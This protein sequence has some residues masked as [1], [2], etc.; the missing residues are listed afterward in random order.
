MKKRIMAVLL[1]IGMLM[2]ACGAPVTEERTQQE[3]G[4]VRDESD[5][6]LLMIYMVGSDLESEAG[7]ASRDIREIVESGFD[8]E[9]LE[10]LICTGGT[11]YWWTEGIS[12]EACGIYEVTDGELKPVYTM[13]NKNM[14]EAGT[15]TEFIDYAYGNYMA[16][17]YSL[18]MW[19]HGGGAVL[20][21]GADENYDYDALSLE[22]MD[23]AFK[24]TMLAAD[25]KKFEWVGFDACLMSMIEVADMLSEYADYMLASEEV[26]AGDGWDY[27][28]LKTISNGKYSEGAA[29]TAEI[30][31]AYSAHYENDYKYTPDYTLA[32]LDLSKTNEVISGLENLVAV[33]GDELRSGGYSKIAK[34]RDQA[35]AFGKVSSAGFYDTVDLYD[36]AGQMMALYP[37]QA[38]A[39][40]AAVKDLV[41]Y[42]ETNVHG[43]Y[44]VAVYF[45]YENKEYAEEWLTEYEATDFSEDYV[46]FLRSFT[47]TLSGEQLAE[48]DI[49]EV[50]PVESSEIPGEYFVQLT[51]EQFAN[52]SHAKYSIWEEDSPGTYICWI[53]SSD[54][55]VSEDGKISSGFQGKRYF[56]GDTSG[57][58]LSCCA[59]EIERNEDYVKYAIPILIT[60]AIDENF[61]S[62]DAAYIHFRVD[63]A[64]P[65][66]EIIGIYKN[67]NTD[68]TLFPNRDVVEIVEGDIISPFYFARE[69]AFREDGSVSSFEDW[70]EASGIGDS[71]AVE[72][73]FAVLISDPEEGNEYCC[74]FDVRD[75]QGNS[76]YTNPIYIEY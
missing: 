53:N 75:T 15:L 19:N 61:F 57:N 5:K 7:L 39:L 14:A 11:G 47:G 37:E 6:Q 73:E 59:I 58:S 56:L 3:S 51:E 36:L 69:I 44:G 23:N 20:G 71:F 8:E 35:K 72:G 26:E 17:C 13:E 22:E 45:P 9:N 27:T 67:L 43:A 63:A 62:M 60:P 64:H 30:I 65:E 52:Y 50:A 74:L 10:V 49:S 40:Q 21:F 33:A 38:A 42:K 76:Y 66:G 25:G 41:M 70:E 1:C 54:V 16:D 34:L 31:R 48:W 29:V 46:V 28:V 32:S 18:I 68:S 2:T 4:S 24:E 55:T 12:N